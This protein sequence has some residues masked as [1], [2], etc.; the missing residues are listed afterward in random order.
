MPSN[1]RSIP[2]INSGSMADIAFLLLIFFLVTTTINTDRGIVRKLPPMPQGPP[3]EVDINDRNVLTVLVNSQDRLLVEG[4][5]LSIDRLK[6]KT[7]R[8]V[9]NNGQSPNLSESPQDAVVSLKADRGTSYDM[10]IQVQNELSAAYS[11]IRDNAARRKYGIAYEQ[12]PKSKKKKI[13]DMYPKKISEAEPEDV[14]T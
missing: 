10:Y 14:G 5:A 4:E 12:L 13:Q 3:P 1:K 8:F 7:K 9:T 6:E 11:E 2:E